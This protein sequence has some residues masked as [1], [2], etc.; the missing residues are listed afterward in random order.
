MGP[1]D[2]GRRGILLGKLFQVA[3]TKVSL[4]YLNK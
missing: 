2:D 3:G 4:G 1:R